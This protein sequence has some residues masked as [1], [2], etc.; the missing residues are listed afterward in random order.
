MCCNNVD[1]T[2]AFVDLGV[3]EG[4]ISGPILLILLIN[5]ITKNTSGAH[6]VLFVDA[7]SLFFS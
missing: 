6:F 7:K 3:P 5:G 4:S 1:S 2:I